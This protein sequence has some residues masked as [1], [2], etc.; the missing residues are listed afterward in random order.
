MFL[1]DFRKLK[2]FVVSAE[3][4]LTFSLSELIVGSHLLCSSQ[5]FFCNSVKNK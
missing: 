2:K 1:Y 3:K 4:A 5:I